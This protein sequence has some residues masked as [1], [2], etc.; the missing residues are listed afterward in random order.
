LIERVVAERQ[1][2][3]S[4]QLIASPPVD[5]GA[6]LTN[7]VIEVLG[8]ELVVCGFDRDYKLTPHGREVQEVI[9]LLSDMDRNS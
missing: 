6:D 9:D 5:W 4:Q 8:D 3:L 7:S 1:P 2:D